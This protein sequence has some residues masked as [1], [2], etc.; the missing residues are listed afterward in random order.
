MIFPD[1]VGST[2]PALLGDPVLDTAKHQ[3]ATIAEQYDRLAA[4]LVAPQHRHLQSQVILQRD[5]AYR[6]HRSTVNRF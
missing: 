5:A 3:L 1:L 2:H 6:L 4:M